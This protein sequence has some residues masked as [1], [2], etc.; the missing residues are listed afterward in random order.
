MVQIPNEED[1]P[2]VRE[3]E[4]S[5]LILIKCRFCSHSFGVFTDWKKVGRH[6]FCN[7]MDE[8][9]WD[10]EF[11]YVNNTVL[12]KCGKIVGFKNSKVF[13]QRNSIF[14]HH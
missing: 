9:D 1:M 2:I 4:Y 12:C 14:L 11:S 8:L 5:K 10:V 13:I 7:E 6:Y 3:Y